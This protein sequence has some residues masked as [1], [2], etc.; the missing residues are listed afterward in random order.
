[1]GDAV[2]SATRCS[3]L[4]LLLALGAPASAATVTASEFYLDW[5]D[6]YF[7]TAFADEASLL[8][9]RGAWS[10]TAFEFRV[11]DAPGP[12]LVPV[13]RFF[14][15]AFAPL[16]SHFYT[17]NPVECEIVKANPTWSYEGVA[18]HVFPPAA[19]G[20]CTDATAPVYRLYN[21]GQGGA[22]NHR[23]TTLHSERLK[24]IFRGW[25][26]EG[27]GPLGV[28][29]CVPVTPDVG[30]QRLQAFA[31]TQWSFI[32]QDVDFTAVYSVEFG[33]ILPSVDQDLPYAVHAPIFEGLARWDP[34][35]GKI[36]V[37]LGGGDMVR[38][39]LEIGAD[40]LGTGCA[41]RSGDLGY[42]IFPPP[43]FADARFGPCRAVTAVRN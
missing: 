35:I 6:H 36:V 8:D 2:T 3:L 11:D 37:F 13:C 4:A 26:P 28:A 9:T 29:F 22:P 10:R 32:F 40:G 27:A 43:P 12:G 24:F 19:D 25:L 5:M 20:S 38:M 42:V 15:A 31:N 21:S 23:Y 41:Y 33:P 17:A 7:L 30:A 34:F 16:S 1:M 14:S 39:V 18:F